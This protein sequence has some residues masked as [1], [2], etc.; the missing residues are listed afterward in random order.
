MIDPCLGEW[1]KKQMWDFPGGPVGK[2]LPCNAGD[3]GLIPVKELIKYK[4]H[5]N[6]FVNIINANQLKFCIAV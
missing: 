1:I 6:P 2:K 4:I 5:L 3:W